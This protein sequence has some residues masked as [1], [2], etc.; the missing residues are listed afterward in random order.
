MH[1]KIE[2]PVDVESICDAMAGIDAMIL[3][4]PDGIIEVRF[5]KPA[6]E[7]TQQRVIGIM[8]TLS[9][10]PLEYRQ[11]KPVRSDDEMLESV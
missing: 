7:K 9:I 3:V 5:N 8:N 2:S 4:H 6:T 1:F 11:Q 10:L